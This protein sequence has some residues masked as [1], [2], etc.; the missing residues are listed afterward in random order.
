M[1]PEE[2]R[3][4]LGYQGYT[5]QLKTAKTITDFRKDIC[6]TYFNEAFRLVKDIVKA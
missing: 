5:L 1:V 4:T 6:Q 3:S 2:V